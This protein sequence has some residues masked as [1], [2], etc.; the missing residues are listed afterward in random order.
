VECDFR[1][2]KLLTINDRVSALDQDMPTDLSCLLPALI[3]RV[4]QGDRLA[5][6]ELLRHFSA[7]IFEFLLKM[8]RNAED[9]EDAAQET[10]VKVLKGLTNYDERGQ[11]RAWVFC[12]A[13][14]EGLQVIRKRQNLIQSRTENFSEPLELERVE[15]QGRGPIE[16]IIGLERLQWIRRIVDR[17]PGP[18]RR[19]FLM[20]AE[21]GL[22][23]S[24]I[25]L[26]TKC[27]INTALGRMRNA[28]LKLR[29]WIRSSEACP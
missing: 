2:G 29:R 27:P 28:S 22:S 1:L 25:A 17:L 23:F 12:I 10:M 15:A 19:V 7:E 11:F 24:E 14:R 18:E 4:K 6:D 13:H 8:L 20:R 5:A 3:E 26:L 9:A 16:Q 21:E